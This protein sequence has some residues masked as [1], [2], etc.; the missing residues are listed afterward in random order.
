MLVQKTMATQARVA[1]L[2]AS[3]ENAARLQLE[4]ERFLAQLHIDSVEAAA[5]ADF[6]ANRAKFEARAREIFVV[7]KSRFTLPEKVSAT[8]I[9][10]DTKKRNSD[11]AKKL[12]VETRAKLVAGAD[13]GKLARDLSDDPS[14]GTNAG[15]IG[16]FEK[17]DMDPAFGDA[18]FALRKPGDL[19]EPV[20]SQ[21]GWHIIRLDDRQPGGA[22]TFEQARDGIL[23]ELKKRHVGEKRDEAIAAVRRDPQTQVN[24][25]AVDA[26]TPRVDVDAARRAVAMPPGGPAPA[27]AAAPK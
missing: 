2:D 16:W 7:E 3:P 15:S 6:E 8:H 12:A 18:A 24:R 14:S 4:I 5:A 22:Q 25:E 23:A 20:L 11:E 13:M 19:S 27:P 21:F 10:F 1:K 9:L 26:L 17:K